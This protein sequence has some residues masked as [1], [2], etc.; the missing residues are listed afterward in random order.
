MPPAAAFTRDQL[1]QAL[2][3]V[4][5]AVGDV[6]FV[7]LSLDAIGMPDGCSTPQEAYEMLF[8]GLREVVGDEGTI[9]VPT[10][11]FS[12]CA[13]EDFDQQETPTRGG[14]WSPTTGFLE[15]ARRLPGAV[16][17]GDPIHSV[18]GHGPRAIELLS[19]LPPTCFGVDSVHDRLRR[20]GG[21]ICLIGLGLE[22]ATFRHHTEEM[23]GVP[24]RFKKLFTGQVRNGTAQY[25]EGWVYSVRILAAEGFPDGRPL[26]QAAREAGVCRAARMGSGE[27]LAVDAP[28]YHD[29]VLQALASDPWYSARG[30][31]GDPVALEAARVGTQHHDVTLPPN[32]SMSQMIDAL[33][34]LPRH[35]VSDGYDAALGALSTQLPM[36]IHEYPTGTECWSWIVP[37]K[38]TCHEACLETLDGQR[39]FSVE[40]HPL[41]VVSYSL[42]FEGEVSRDELMAHLHVHPRVDDAIPFIFKYYERDWGLCCSRVLRDTLT[43]ERYRVVIRTSFSYGTLKVG[44]VVV[45]GQRDECVILCAH[46]CHPAMVNDD[47]SGVVVGMDV[48]RALRA[49]GNLRYTYRLLIVPETIGSVAWLSHNEAL[50][51]R[52]KGGLFLEMLGLDT[53]H[54][55]QLSFTG[56]S[57]IDGAFARALMARDPANWATGFR[58]L[59]GNDERQFNAPGVRVPMLSLTRMLPPSHPMHPYREYHSSHDTPAITVP[60]RLEDSRETVLQMIEAFE[61]T[62]IPVNRFPGELFCSRYGIHVDP[63]TNPEGSRAFFDMLSLIDGTRSVDDIAFACGIST[64]AVMRTIGELRRH[65]VVDA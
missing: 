48:M 54:A 32:A 35:I 49:R 44:Q 38:W 5:L 4:G 3:D 21:K 52:M 15:Y 29:F 50:I 30:P 53:S 39:L 13:Q 12:F 22:E 20:A 11:T 6:V 46:L 58:T 65:G 41:H 31:A 34:R 55:L 2:R 36:T 23:A 33:W 28:A 26:E 14:P 7:H 57:A 10:Y 18:V 25:K 45:P 19:M 61:R 8:D 16:R 1:T 62:V 60:A 59:M 9:L 47:L 64:D 40:D 27:I 24:F 37:E 17:S 42:P 51:P 43:A 63:Y 56:T